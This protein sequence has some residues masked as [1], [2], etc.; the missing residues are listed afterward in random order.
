MPSRPLQHGY[1]PPGNS[2]LP[3]HAYY[4]GQPP[5]THLPPASSSYPAGDPPQQH[6][7]GPQMQGPHYQGK[8]DDFTV[9]LTPILAMR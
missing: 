6:T 8:T 3:Q 1:F 4:L 2:Y 5:P 9:N 7:L